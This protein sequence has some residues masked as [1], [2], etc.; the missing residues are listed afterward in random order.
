MINLDDCI[1]LGFITKPSGIK[2]QLIIRLSKTNFEDII[3]LEQVF[4]QI[5][6]LPVPFFIESSSQKN[7]EDLLVKFEGIDSELTARKLSD[8][9]VYLNKKFI[10]YTSATGIDDIHQFEG[11]SVE[12]E[13]LGYVG[14]LE[15]VLAH[16][17]NP[18]ML[19]T[20]KAKEFYIP[21]HEDFLISIDTK[22]NKIIVNCPPGLLEIND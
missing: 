6:G 7:Y 1:E 8:S 9:K 3:K 18:L 12:D 4:V 13:Q 20:N 5:D 15:S 11:Y 14:K 10:A 21:L 17:N 2:G 22:N 16:A 19:V